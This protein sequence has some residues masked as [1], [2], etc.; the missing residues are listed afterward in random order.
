LATIRYWITSSAVANSVSGMERS[1]VLPVLRL[2]ISSI[3]MACWTGRSAGFSAALGR[4]TSPLLSTSGNWRR[5]G[6]AGAGPS[7]LPFTLARLAYSAAAAA[8]KAVRLR[9]AGHSRRFHPVES[10]WLLFVRADECLTPELA[11]VGGLH[12]GRLRW[13]QKRRL[14]RS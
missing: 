4:K 6:P 7:S 2:R 5:K 8:R 10:R 3:L 11:F 14:A 9:S 12:C 13:N 1:R